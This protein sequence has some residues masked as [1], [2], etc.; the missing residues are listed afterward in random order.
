MCFLAFLNGAGYYGLVE[1]RTVSGRLIVL[2]WELG[3]CIFIASYTANLAQEL[4]AQSRPQVELSAESFEALRASYNKVCLR[5]GTAISRLVGPQLS[6]QQ[7]VVMTG[8]L[9]ASQNKAAEA[10]RRGGETGCEGFIQPLW[11][12]Q[13]ML[14]RAA[15]APCDLRIVYP[16]ISIASGGYIT[17][18]AWYRAQ[19]S[20]SVD[21]SCVGP[22]NQALGMLL[23]DTAVNQVSQFRTEQLGRLREASCALDGRSL[24]ADEAVAGMQLDYDHFFGLFLIMGSTLIFALLISPPMQQFFRERITQNAQTFSFYLRDK[25]DEANATFFEQSQPSSFDVQASKQEV[26]ASGMSLSAA[27][28]GSDAPDVPHAELKRGPSQADMVRPP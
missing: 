26:D 17:A 11:M 28:P 15:N 3:C 6:P 8:G 18:S 12:A 19:T 27:E 22:L 16:T 7:V 14:V 1:S 25:W 24:D 2:A 10:L 5:D 9:Y 20:P 21:A 13:D 23:Q 4:L